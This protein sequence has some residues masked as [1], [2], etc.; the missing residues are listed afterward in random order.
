MNS[1]ELTLVFKPDLTEEKTDAIISKLGVEVKSK[2]AW[3][4]RLLAYPID[5]LQEG[6]YVHAAIAADPQAIKKIEQSLN[7]NRSVVRYL[8]VKAD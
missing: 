1:Y 5:R 3:G 2:T 6:N 4:K 8:L 7:H